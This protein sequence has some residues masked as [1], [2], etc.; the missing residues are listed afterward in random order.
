MNAPPKQNPVAAARAE[1]AAKSRAAAAG[2]GDAPAPAAAA[3]EPV[4]LTA[5][6]ERLELLEQRCDDLEA[7]AEPDLEPD[8]DADADA[9]ADADD[10]EAHLPGA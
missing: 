9:A 8:A 2:N 3:G 7:D 5:I 10:L 1:R 6:L 4:D